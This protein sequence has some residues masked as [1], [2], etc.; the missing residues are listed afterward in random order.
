VAS[1]FGWVDFADQDRDRMLDVIQQFRDEG[2]RDELGVGT[3]R[4]AFANF[5]FPG[6]STIQTRVRYF[7]FLPWIYRAL[8]RKGVKSADFARRAR[9]DEVALIHTL[10]ES[11][12]H[13]GT[14]GNEAK[15]KLQRFPSSVYWS[16]LGAWGIRS[17]PGSE[18]QYR[19]S[20]DRYYRQTVLKGEDQEPLYEVPRENWHSSIPDPPED[21]PK[22]ASFTLQPEESEYLRERIL[23]THPGSLLAHL[24]DRGESYDVNFAWELPWVKELPQA[25]QDELRHAQRFSEAIYGASILYNLLLARAQEA[26]DLIDAYEADFA[27]WAALMQAEHSDFST[28]FQNRA[29][30]WS[31]AA[32]AEAR[33]PSRTIEF[34]NN[35]LEFATTTPNPLSL[36][37]SSAVYDLLAERETRLKGSR[38]KLSNE[39]AR[40]L[41]QGAAGA[42]KL[43][44]RWPVAN[45]LVRDILAG[46]KEGGQADA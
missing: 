29:Q 11:D 12:D 20:L 15:E 33:I 44:Y 36:R 39:R 9:T 5:F 40:E 43:N 24:V 42:F 28:W 45:R 14:I 46:L 18:E 8:E 22:K 31:C 38:A 10:L 1:R 41:W 19:R 3:I 17:F 37:D 25:L 27:D 30:F 4:D 26:Q 2:A 16:G 32:L 13:Q 23:D 7:L 6:T 21:W 34:V 35:W